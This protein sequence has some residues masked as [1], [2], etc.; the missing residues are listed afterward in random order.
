MGLI[1]CKVKKANGEIADFFFLTRPKISAYGYYSMNVK[2]N[3]ND[4]VYVSYEREINV[5]AD[6]IFSFLER[7]GADIEYHEIKS[8]DITKNFLLRE[9]QL[10]EERL[11]RESAE[12]KK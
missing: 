1:N 3:S 5:L 11:K 4:D 7:Q 10:K 2:D 12:K 8:D 6:N 9:K